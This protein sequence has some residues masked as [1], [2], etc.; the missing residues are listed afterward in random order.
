MA[1][2]L[3]VIQINHQQINPRLAK[4]QIAAAKYIVP[5]KINSWNNSSAS[6]HVAEIYTIGHSDSS[7]SLYESEY[8]VIA[9]D[10]IMYN[11]TEVIKM[12]WGKSVDDTVNDTILLLES[13]EKWGLKCL[14]L[15]K[16]DYSFLIYNK[17]TGDFFCARDPLGIRPFFYTIT[18]D[19]FIFG[20]ELRFVKATFLAEPETNFGYILDT[21]VT[22]KSD[23][24]ETAFKNI[25]RIKPAHY[26]FYE[27]G[28]FLLT[29]FWQFSTDRKI[30]C[31][32]TDEYE[33]IFRNA[34]IKA[35]Q[36]RLQGVDSIGTE[37]S[38]GL[39]S[40]AITGI[41]NSVANSGQI[42]ITA[43][44]NVL[45]CDHPAIY[46]DESE[47]IH[48]QLLYNP[49]DWA[50]IEMLKQNTVE[51]VSHALKIQGCFTQQN[52][53]IFNKGLFESVSHKKIGVLLSG[54]GGDEMISARIS[55][56]WNEILEDG[57]FNVFFDELFY[58]GITFHS[59]FKGIKIVG[60]YILSKANKQI[61]TNRK[62]SNDLL[63]KRFNQLPIRD[64]FS[65][66][67]NLKTRFY[68]KY[69]YVSQYKISQQQ[70]TRITQNYISQHLDLSYAA[71]AQYGI[72]YRYP[73]LD[74]E[75]LETYLSFP[76]Q[77][78]NHY[79]INRYIFREAIKN[80]IPEKIW[81]R[82][83]KS[84]MTIPH[85]IMRLASDREIILSTIDDC[86]NSAYLREIFEFEKFPEWFGELIKQDEKKNY[87]FLPGAFCN[88]LMMML[89]FKD[90]V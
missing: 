73:L 32:S 49:M 3:G 16:G 84:F 86:S 10:I 22:R 72:E 26:L 90:H 15:I 24:H 46:K 27:K 45:P 61:Y 14:P 42:P 62:F 60:E 58:Q 28:K 67:H 39:D 29:R 75:L 12:L 44:S 17:K 80:F 69:R 20:S 2:F 43:F 19:S 4:S 30:I 87:Y 68:D 66:K 56:P 33:K 35:I 11:R 23:T 51:L 5:R 52:F 83:D 89:Y 48:Q 57:Q 7:T 18:T 81:S 70:V 47:Y 13:F 38:G 65:D 25:L 77:V 50:G 85:F 34:L 54:F 40:S 36:I 6:I 1:S 53:H 55:F 59:F 71:A 74:V 63:D 76:S 82:N 37:L 9:A 21:L 64:D 88:Y 31:K 79:G 8:Y 78:V 41:A